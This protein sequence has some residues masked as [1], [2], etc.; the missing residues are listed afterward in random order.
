M[1]GVGRVQGSTAGA[2]VDRAACDPEKAY[3]AY[4]LRD[5]LTGPIRERGEKTFTAGLF[6]GSESCLELGC[7]FLGEQMDKMWMRSLEYPVAAR[8]SRLDVPR[9]AWM[10]LRRKKLRNRMR[11]IT[12]CHLCKLKIQN[13]L[14]RK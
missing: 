1:P 13:N 4:N 12:K 14:S 9:A 6:M 11:R 8:S 2:C 3:P 7:P 10:G 5:V